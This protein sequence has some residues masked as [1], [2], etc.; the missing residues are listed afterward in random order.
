YWPRVTPR[1]MSMMARLVTSARPP[2]DPSGTA[3]PSWPGG[4]SGGARGAWYST[5][6]FAPD[7]LEPP[8]FRSSRGS[9]SGPFVRD[10]RQGVDGRVQP[11]VDRFEPGARTSPLP[12]EPPAV[13]AYPRRPHHSRARLHALSPNGD[14]VGPLTE[15]GR[16]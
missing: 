16:R 8:P 10:L 13:P 12:A 9:F 3:P 5:A 2:M 15:P 6:P 11:A 1:T 14:E 4:A 7:R